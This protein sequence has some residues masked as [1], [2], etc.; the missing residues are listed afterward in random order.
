MAT[1]GKYT[2]EAPKP[3]G[4]AAGSGG[5]AAPDQT[6]VLRA[7]VPAPGAGIPKP[8]KE[9]PKKSGFGK[10]SGE[11]APGAVPGKADGK[12][13]GGLFGRKDGK[14]K[15]AKG[16]TPRAAG[17]RGPQTTESHRKRLT[18]MCGVFAAIAVGSV[19]FGAAE[20]AS[21]N[22]IKNAIYGTTTP[23][24]VLTGDVSGG[25]VIQESQLKIADV[26]TTYV[27]SDAAT[28]ISQVAGKTA[29]VNLH[30]NS[31]ISQNSITGSENA[32]SLDVAV[33]AGNVG[34]MT[35]LSGAAAASPMV[36]PGDRVDIMTSDKDGNASMFATGVRVLAVDGK[37]ADDKSGNGYSTMTFDL[38]PQQAADLFELIDVRGGSI[39]LV[40][41]PKTNDSASNA[42][43]A[44]ASASG[45][46]TAP[47]TVEAQG[48]AA[49]ETQAAPEAQ[50]AQTAPTT[51][52]A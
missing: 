20:L 12:A 27:P 52:G 29:V 38:T 5:K 45:G 3:K 18:I 49:P 15:A 36:K 37:L 10:P 19:A 41:P 48:Q 31:A 44:S 7:A 25:S 2:Y 6:T 24:V 34:Y 30:A 33:S 42:T 28:E 23:V 22:G 47:T 11:K 35:S 17:P 4:E 13:K 21:A 46:T 16:T 1:F 8:P 39:H 51:A 26:P 32:T 50:Q 14:A 9:P 40:I 43:G